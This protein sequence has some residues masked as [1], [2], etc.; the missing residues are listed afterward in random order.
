MIKLRKFTLYDYEELVDMHYEFT[1]EVYPDRK[2]GYRYSFYMIV[3]DW[4]E[5]KHDIVLAVK[6]DNICGFTMSYVDY[7]DGLTEPV[8]RGEIAYVKPEYR[9]TRVGHMLYSNVVRYA[10]ELE[11]KLVSMSR[12]EN[13]IDKMVI[14][15]F[16]AIPKYIMM[17]RS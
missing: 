16:N 17:E 2:L 13:G 12:I 4:I 9:K 15:H 5:K 1:K 10:E 11:L 3:N 8:Y 14:K 7:V 6:D